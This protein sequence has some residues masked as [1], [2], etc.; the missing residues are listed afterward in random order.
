MGLRRRP[1]G[2]PFPA[3]VGWAM[4]LMLFNAAVEL[5]TGLVLAAT[6]TPLAAVAYGLSVGFVVLAVGLARLRSWAWTWSLAG[7]VLGMAA[8]VGAMLVTQDPRYLPLVPG[9]A[10]VVLLMPAVRRTLRPAA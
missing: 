7:T 6:S 2:G 9:I 1:P 5:F 8:G 4:L 3:V 10:L